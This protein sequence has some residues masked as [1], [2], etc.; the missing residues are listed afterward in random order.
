[1]VPLFGRQGS[2]AV[3]I[4]EAESIGGSQAHARRPAT[5]RTP[6]A[7]F[8]LGNP[9]VAIDVYDSERHG[10]TVLPVPFLA[11]NETVAVPVQGAEPVRLRYGS[12]RG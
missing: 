8:S 1:M 9:A 12:G 2:V 11:R 7:Q 5:C 6:I 3:A 4:E 10:R